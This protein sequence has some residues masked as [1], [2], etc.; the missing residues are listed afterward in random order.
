MTPIIERNTTI[1]SQKKQV[2]STAADNQPAVTVRVLQ[3]ER[4]M[5][6]DN[7]EIGRF[8]LSDIPPAPR[9][10]PDRGDLRYR[11][12]RDPPRLGK[13][14]L[15]GKEQ[16]IRIQAKSG[17]DEGEIQRVVPDAE[18]HAAEDKKRKQTRRR[19]QRS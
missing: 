1:P 3:G 16:K 17:L 4:P 7:K 5:A 19:A 9:G 12:R 13:R 15:V 8:D 18:A 2:F 10:F 6:G 11:C 14:P